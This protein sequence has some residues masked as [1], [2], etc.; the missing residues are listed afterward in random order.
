LRS[1]L[2]LVELGV[3]MR[4]WDERNLILVYVYLATSVV[5]VGVGITFALLTIC[6]N[7][8]VDITQHYWLLS[9]PPASSLILNVLLIELYRKIAKR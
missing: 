9:I 6:W 7:N 8:G 3:K 4:R 2:L 1:L 5:F